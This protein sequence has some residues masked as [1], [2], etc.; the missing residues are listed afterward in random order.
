MNTRKRVF[1]RA[2]VWP[3]I[4][5]TVAG[6]MAAMVGVPPSTPASAAVSPYSVQSDVSIPNTNPALTAVDPFSEGLTPANPLKPP[7]PFWYSVSKEGLTIMGLRDE[8]TG[9]LI[10]TG[11]PV[12]VHKNQVVGFVPWPDDISLTQIDG[13]TPTDPV[14]EPDKFAHVP[15][16][17]WKPIGMTVSYPTDEAL[18]SNSETPP[19]YVY[20]VMKGSGY[21][22]ASS[23]DNTPN[24]G[25]D[26]GLRDTIRPATPGSDTES[27]L[28]VQVDVSDPTYPADLFPT[29]PA[30]G[31]GLLGHNAGQP[32]FDPAMDSVYTGNMPSTSL[33][34]TPDVP[35]DLTSFVSVTMLAPAE[36]PVPGEVPAP[37]TVTVL[38]GPEHPDIPLLAGVPEAWA[39]IAEGGE[40]PFDW[41][42]TGLPGWLQAHTDPLTGKGDGV[43]YGTP[44]AG[45]YTF[46][47]HV[48][49]NATTPPGT[50]DATITLTVTADPTTEYEYGEL[51]WEVG[52]PAA[53]AIEGTPKAG[54]SAADACQLAPTD[55]PG[56]IVP[57]WVDVKEVSDFGRHIDNTSLGGPVENTIGC[58]VMGT[59]PISGER[60]EFQMPNMQFTWPSNNLPIVFSGQV[61]G[62][63]TFDALPMGVGLSGLAWHEIDKIH[64]AS[65]EADLLNREFFG[66]EPST[67]DMYRIVP[68]YA[69]LEAE[70]TVVPPPALEGE[71]DEV[72]PFTNVLTTLTDARPDIAQALVEHPNLSVQFGNVA[73][74]AKADPNVFVAATKIADPTGVD[75]TVIPIGD[76][77]GST[78]DMTIGAGA[79]VNVSATRDMSNPDEMSALTDP[80]AKVI[81]LAGVQARNLGLD[82]D[83]APAVRDGEFK[84]P[85]QVDNGVLMVTGDGLRNVAVVDTAAAKMA[86][87]LAVS[88]TG[89][90]GG[91]SFYPQ[92]SQDAFIAGLSS[93]KV[94]IA[95][96]GEATEAVPKIVSSDAAGFTAGSP[97]GFIVAATGSPL[98]SLS[99]TG[100][101]PA[102][103]TFVDRGDGTAMLAGTPDVG[104]Q[105]E[106]PLTIS[107]A[108]GI[109]PDAV[110][111]FVLSVYPA[112]DVQGNWVGSYGADGYVLG[113]WNGTSDLV[114]LRNATISLDQGQRYMWSGD[115]TDIRAL[116]SP[117]Q[118][119]RK[120][121]T[122]FDGSQLGLTM[123]FSSAYSGNLHVYAVDWDATDRR[124]TVTVTDGAGGQTSA[125]DASFNNG[126]WLTFPITVATGGTVTITATR[127]AGA[128]AVISGLF[129][130]ES[131]PR[132]NWVGTY[133]ADGYVL[134]AWTGG[135]DLAVLPND[136]ATATLTD[137]Q[138]FVWNGDTT[139]VR[140]LQSPDQATRKAATWYGDTHVG[141]SLTF[142]SGYVGNLHLYAVDW[143]STSRQQSVDVTDDTGKQTQVLDA[144]F[145]GGVWL[146]YPIK[147]AA[148]NSVTIDVT[149]I[150][151]ANAVLSGL[152]LGEE[153][154]PPMPPA[155]PVITSGNAATFVTGTDGFFQVESTGSPTPTLTSSG[156]LPAGV[157]FTDNGTG[158]ASLAGTPDAG[159]AGD[160]TLKITA[161]NS[162]GS[163]DQ[164]FTLHVN[165][166]A[167][168]TS[169]NNA[170][171][172]VGV[173]GSFNVTATGRPTPTL[174]QTGT[175]PSGVTFTNN[176][177]GTATLAGTPGAGT[178]GTY[179]LSIKATNNV[180][181]SA[182][183]AFT[184]Q[185]NEKPAITSASSVTFGV[186]TAGTF[187]VTAT[188][189][190]K[191]TLSVTGTL[192]TGV[193]FD[194][195]TGRLA[196]TPAAGTVGS[197]PLT[198]TA[199][200]V[201]GTVT[202]AFTLTVDNVVKITNTSPL[203]AGRQGTPYSLQ[204][205][206]TGGIGSYTWALANNTR[207]P[208]GLRLSTSG[209][210]SGTPTSRGTT[211]FTVRA[212]D[213]EGHFATKQFTITI[214]RR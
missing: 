136:I 116:Q 197:Y 67:G 186:E 83:L 147:A 18:A 23:N 38:C 89:A 13:E 39:C 118:S 190:P 213:S 201:A 138:R 115:T 109:S 69:G 156:A 151:G 161:A 10:V 121:A 68:A 163:V 189:T 5:G 194:S 211:T 129:L 70:G 96:P 144:P 108:N 122:W 19:T 11:Q 128:N 119:T 86:Q 173:A 159:T 205:Q 133:G 114:R 111:H 174:S 164:T 37:V 125:L 141:V 49:D 200:N 29:G 143:D 76:V 178:A 43:L 6:V 124:E 80:T 14:A 176:G 185:V 82:S 91:L 181:P 167:A 206:A 130:G 102:G 184:L 113:G 55:S 51:E 63:Y 88:G 123:K 162:L 90:L 150:A 155:Q 182:T 62:P 1:T 183:Q 84:E 207:L 106:Y 154:T 146:S 132:G 36:L 74:E 9:P 127:D 107:A 52:T 4:V 21:E 139:D 30:I 142:P 17:G 120:A 2:R 101:L 59:P 78:N 140:A 203:P 61:G 12:V 117:D 50:G 166:P 152:F 98:P 65:T 188:G 149:K 7:R 20:V 3:V 95:S 41:T 171:F 134:G 75:P 180:G 34:S 126:A 35:N 196:G 97:G 169:A 160:Y 56:S 93:Q 81:D 135:G 73:A 99:S 168:I 24:N 104:A 66:V 77:A 177:D 208:V 25:I 153:G 26:P 28:L 87:V 100:D 22:W 145:D 27:D 42:F 170:A 32:T 15:E 48:D 33:P 137:G 212:T 193:T 45:T 64:D 46:S 54:H 198:I 72:E 94:T 58:F 47:A 105:G 16:G 148:G 53:V 31:A 110:Q 179:P 71:L 112:T 204:F 195:T 92:G 57:E 103:V 199:T 8:T 214:N 60:Y 202:Q 209:L 158:T 79:L 192:P 165:A 40:G 187:Q 175:L 85:G 131:S 210:L 172:V 44:P 191:P 157:S